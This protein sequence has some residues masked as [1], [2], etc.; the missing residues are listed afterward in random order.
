MA[1]AEKTVSALIG[2][3]LPDFVRA[4]NPQFQA[5]LQ[6]YYRWLEDETKGNTVYHIMR[7][8]EY[9]DIDNTLDPF[10]RLFKQE[11]LPYFPEKSELDLVK[12][13]KGAREFYVKKGSI[14]SV[15]WLFRVLF[16][17]DV[18]IYYPKQ[19]V[20]IASDGKWKLPQAFQ[21]TLS[22]ENASIDVNLLEKHK[23]TGSIS[24]ATCIIESANK[25]VDPSRGSLLKKVLEITPNNAVDI[26]SDYTVYQGGNIAP[27]FSATVDTYY[28]GN[29]TLVITNTSGSYD[30]TG[31]LYIID[32]ATEEI[33]ITATLLNTFTLHGA[34][35]LEMYVSNVEKEF[36]NGEYLEI[37]YV[38]ENGV[39]QLFRERIIGSIS[40]VIMDSDIRTD[41]DGRRRGRTYKVGDPIVFYGGLADSVEANDAVAIVGNVTVGSIEGLTVRFPGYGY[42]TYW[43]TEAIVYRSEDDDPNA[44]LSTDIRVAGITT[45]VGANSQE[46]YLETISVDK[47]PIEYMNTTVIGDGSTFY[48]LFSNTNKNIVLTLS[49]TPADDPWI[50]GEY[51]YANSNGSFE[52]ANFTAQILSANTGWAG[53]PT[54][55]I[56]YNVN[57]TVALDTTGFLVGQTLTTTQSLTNFDVDALIDLDPPNLQYYLDA[58]LNTQ[59]VQALTYENI[60]TGGIALYNVINGGYGFAGEPSVDTQSYFDTLLSANYDYANTAEYPDKVNTRQS[61][62]VFGHIAHIYIDNG[63]DGYANGETVSVS[64]RGYGFNGVVTVGASGEITSVDILDRGAGYFG[65]ITHRT[66]TVNTVSGANAILTAYGFGE[67]VEVAVETGAIGRIRDVRMISRGFD[68][69]DEPLVSFKVVDMIID[70]VDDNETL[71]EGERVYQGATLETALFQGIVKSYNRSTKR[72]R[73]FNYSGNTSY[74]TS[75][76]FTSQGGVQFTVNTS[77]NVPAPAEYPAALRAT[78]LTNPYFYGNGK[79]KGYAEFYQGLIKFPG[80]YLNTDGFPSSDKRLQD[81]RVYQNY[82]YVIESEKSLSEYENTMKDIIHPIGTLM[83][84]RTITRSQLQEG[85]SG[86]SVIYVNAENPVSSQITIANSWSNVVTGSS[87]T[88]SSNANVGDMLYLVDNYPGHTWRDQVKIITAVNSDTELEVE[89]NFTYIG[90]GKLSSEESNDTVLIVGHDKSLS[91]FVN[92]GDEIRFNANSYVETCQVLSMGANTLTLNTTIGNTVSNVVYIVAPDYSSL[93]YDYEII[94][95]E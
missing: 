79:A 84:S 59:I 58:N 15:Q 31:T 21:L 43:N 13:L 94:T 48:P 19:Q 36:T 18:E 20:L 45:L 90:Y 30:P 74:T 14:E 9:R 38:D 55:V 73:L 8:G 60:D 87:T 53:G 26:L 56:L 17:E 2:R 33:I 6:A 68:Y 64:G 12:I 54:N 27:T 82:S 76:V 42:R 41:P 52:T 32:P 49:Q 50:P 10:I 16:G 57:S 40:G 11:L 24:K 88:W 95:V 77:A 5:F 65:G 93:P 92:V 25:T 83:L 7:S 4:D 47:M 46:S 63:G 85:I 37:P 80:F 70:G 1:A 51:V 75:L 72:L 39:E 66:V 86:N 69:I 67:G 3:Q 28:T 29:T 61:L 35:L 34:E 89:S 78:G 81:G 62:G 71:S 23:A 22:V 44:N 91:S